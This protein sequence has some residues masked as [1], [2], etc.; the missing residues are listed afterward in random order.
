MIDPID[1]ICCKNLIVS[2]VKEA[3]FTNLSSCQSKWQRKKYSHQ[4]LHSQGGKMP[5]FYLKNVY[6]WKILV[7]WHKK[8]AH[9]TI[10]QWGKKVPTL[11]KMLQPQSKLFS[12]FVVETDNRITLWRQERSQTKCVT[13]VAESLI[14]YH[15]IPTVWQRPKKSKVSGRPTFTRKNFPDEARQSFPRHICQKCVIRFHNKNAKSRCW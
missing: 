1:P 2:L 14:I 15:A 7:N 12:S 5:T 4:I 8:C 3:T 11:T 9:Q 10:I 6:I 13:L